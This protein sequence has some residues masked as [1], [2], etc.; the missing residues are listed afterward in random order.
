LLGLALRLGLAS[1]GGPVLADQEILYFLVRPVGLLVLVVIAALA[2]TLITLELATLMAIA[3]GAAPGSGAHVG[4]ALLWSSRRAPAAL[5]L[6][7]RLVARIVLHALPFL[8][9]IGLVYLA[10]LRQFDINF[11]LKQKPASFLAAVALVALLV[12]GLVWTL[13]PRIVGWV[14][15]LPLALFERRPATDAL[16]E[17]ARRVEA[18]RPVVVRSLA[19]WAA[20]ALLLSLGMPALLFAL[21][22]SIARYGRD[23]VGLVLALLLAIA[24][25]WSIVN[26]LV[27]CFN[28]STFALLLVRLFERSGGALERPAAAPAIA[29]AAP[30]PRLTPPR[31]LAA[32]VALVVV[33]AAAG[34]FL[35][36]A[37]GAQD[38]VV[39]IAHRGAS[40]VAPENTLAAVTA[41]IDQGA[42]FIEIDVQETL[43]G[44]IVVV[45]DSDFM[46][47]SRVDLKV[48]GGAWDEVQ[49]IDVGSWFGPQFAN[50]RVPRLRDVLERARGRAKV[51]IELKYYG[52]DQN[53]EQR[54]IDLVEQMGMTQDVILM[55]LEYDAVE[56]C[57]RC[58]RGGRSGCSPRPRW[59]ISPIA[60]PT[61]SRSTAGSPTARSYGVRTPRASRSTSGPSTTRSGCSR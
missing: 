42:D 5:R 31:I 41:A 29:A 6:S 11:Y 20:V 49:G 23:N 48:W 59:A 8:A 14:L 12:L 24:T 40:A 45:H 38:H 7:I 13:V 3:A 44:E 53:L 46:R 50:E 47:T 39:V 51:T 35:L 34:L 2:L 54:V 21:G 60:T 17:S 30:T 55:S 4:E 32:V 22:R 58:G 18:S 52:H 16:A 10:L 43:D 26:L 25:V 56:S 36:R 1:S 9:G 19:G 15:A 37:V 33:G 57:S 61:S 28:T 27:T